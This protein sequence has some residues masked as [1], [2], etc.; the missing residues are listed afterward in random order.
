MYAEQDAIVWVH[1]HWERSG[2]PGTDHFSAMASV[3]RTHQLV[4]ATMDEVLK[5][6]DITRTGYLLMTTLLMTRDHTRPLGQLSRHLMVHPTTVTLVIDQL[7]KRDLVRRSRH[8]T[9]RRTVLAT[10]TPT[11]LT[12]TSLATKALADVGFGLDGTGADLARQVTSLLGRVRKH[13]GDAG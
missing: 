2:Q 12:Q 13:L 9:D 7:E 8:D 1:E 10:L 3:L 5:A 6:H 4:T 11:G